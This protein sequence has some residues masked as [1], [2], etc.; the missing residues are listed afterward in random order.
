MNKLLQINKSQCLINVTDSLRRFNKEAMIILSQ[1]T[2]I[3]MRGKNYQ[4]SEK[5]QIM[6]RING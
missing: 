1:H 5:A 4:V 6:E 3:D 2:Y